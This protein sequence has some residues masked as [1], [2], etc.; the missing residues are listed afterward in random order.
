MVKF[1]IKDVFCIVFINFFEYYLL[2]FI[3]EKK[4]YCFLM[5]VSSLC[6]IFKEFS[7]VLVWVMYNR[8]K[9]FGI[10]Y[11]FDDFFFIVFSVLNCCED[12]V[13]FFFFCKKINIFINMEKMVVFII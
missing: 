10:F 2:G 4:F 8:Y 11:I 5:G 6:K 1:D 3:L 12:L 7:Q 9:V 13:C